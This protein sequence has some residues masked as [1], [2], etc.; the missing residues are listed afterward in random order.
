M[1]RDEMRH[2]LSKS[3][4]RLGGLAAVIAV[5][6]AVG[7]PLAASASPDNGGPY[8][9]SAAIVGETYGG[10]TPQGWPVVI[11]LSKNQRRVVRAVVGL[12]LACPSGGFFSYWNRFV[13]LRVNTR[14]KFRASFGPD[15]QRYDDGTT[16]DFEGSISG[17]LNRARSRV[18]GKSRLKVT[19]YNTAGVVTDT[20]DSGSISWSARE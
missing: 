3:A 20:C 2:R 13:D 16:A 12:D 14:R 10:V 11:Q 1:R 17:A 15:T 18:S 4:S 6:A 7:V 19:N 9:R 8:A 5:T